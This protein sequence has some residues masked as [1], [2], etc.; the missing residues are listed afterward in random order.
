VA[1]WGLAYKENTRSVKNSPALAT[2]AQFPEVRFR[3]HDPAV[4][5][6]AARHPRATEAADPLAAAAGAD[7][8]MILTPWPDYRTI[9]PAGIARALAGRVVIDP[10]RVLDPAAASAAGLDHHALGAPPRLVGA[11]HAGAGDAAAG[12]V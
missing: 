6:S 2:L 8:L 1:V 5:A 10:Y 7:A 11:R 9:A 4:P 12:K 3:L